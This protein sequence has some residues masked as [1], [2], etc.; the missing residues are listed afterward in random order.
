M[1]SRRGRG[2]VLFA[3]DH[4]FLPMDRALAAARALPLDEESLAE[5]LG[6]AA[7]RLLGV[8]DGG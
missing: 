5:F 1:G 3:S 7:A 2:R 8:A 6:A 4:P